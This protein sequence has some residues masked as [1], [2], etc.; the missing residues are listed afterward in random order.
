MNKKANL[1][2]FHNFAAMLEKKYLIIIGG[3]T[4]SGKTALAIQLA[5]YFST[6][7][8]S[9]DSRQFY[10]EMTIGTAKPSV[11]ELKSVPHHFINNLSIQDNYSV[12]DYEKEVLEKL[13][14]LFQKQDIVIMVG[15]TGLYIRAVCEGL[16]SF[17][18]VPLS[19]RADLEALFHEQGIEALQKELEIVDP[20]YFE[21]VDKDNPMR[22][23]RALSVHRASGQPFSS[24]RTKNSVNRIFEP[25]Y[26]ALDIPRAILYDRINLRVDAMIEMGLIQE[27]QNLI[28]FKHL[29]AL[30]TVGYSELFHYFENILTLDEAIDKIK[31]HT[32]NYAKRQCTWFRKDKHWQYFST[33]DVNDIIDYLKNFNLKEKQ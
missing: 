29:N 3:P 30:Q 33:P 7:I 10:R 15:G 26:I 4:A 28:P 8:I 14:S 31:Q 22:L 27:V 19:I 25:I 18:D 9:A 23:I 24:F 13:D 11:E 20:I 1:E 17:P 2:I 16:D 21:E 5:Q 12:G 32:R 6:E